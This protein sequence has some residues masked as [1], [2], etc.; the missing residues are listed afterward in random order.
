MPKQFKTNWEIMKTHEN[1]EKWD[2]IAKYYANEI[3]PNIP[4]DLV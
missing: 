1:I 2:L 3:D 4:I